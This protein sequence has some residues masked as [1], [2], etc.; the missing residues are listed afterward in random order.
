MSSVFSP[1]HL[2]E[3]AIDNDCTRYYRIVEHFFKKSKLIKNHELL[4]ELYNDLLTNH[5]TDYIYKNELI[6]YIGFKNN[7]IFDEFKIGNSIANVVALDNFVTVYE[8]ITDLNKLNTLDSN[9]VSY[10]HFADKIYILT[11]QSYMDRIF[12][13]YKYTN[14]GILV[15]NDNNEII[16]LKKATACLSFLNSEIL[17]NV[18]SEKEYLLLAK[19]YF[20]F[21]PI[22]NKK[23]ANECFNLLKE[24]PLFDF[25]CYVQ[26]L[27][28]NRNPSNDMFSKY[29]I[30]NEL[31][32][33]CKLLNFEGIELRRLIYF[34][35]SEIH[36]EYC[37]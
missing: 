31:K 12:I 16:K 37:L 7:V 23:V 14:I 9:I 33:L 24:L 35:N 32:Y 6:K 2:K 21:V 1:E 29:N 27:L 8:I 4:T 36:V 22:Q 15:L 18:L 13:K 26:E 5:R 19:K 20:N 3:I 17:F 10:Q 34:L 11:S 30:P 28:I 25:H